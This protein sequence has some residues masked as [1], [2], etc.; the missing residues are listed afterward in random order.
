VSMKTAYRREEADQDD[1]E[2]EMIAACHKEE[3]SHIVDAAPDWIDC[4][5]SNSQVR[6]LRAGWLGMRIV[7]D[8]L[9]AS[10]R[11]RDCSVI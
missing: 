2:G 5:D 4:Y 6:G 3:E 10:S 8:G 1:G 9:G 7:L 11:R